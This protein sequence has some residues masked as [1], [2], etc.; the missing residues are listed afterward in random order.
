MRWVMGHSKQEQILKLI[1]EY[2]SDKSLGLNANDIIR[3]KQKYINDQRSYSEILHELTI[4]K[5]NALKQGLSVGTIK[6]MLNHKRFEEPLTTMQID[7]IALG[8]VKSGIDYRTFESKLRSVTT[9]QE[10]IE[11]IDSL[12]DEEII[13]DEVEVA[14]RKLLM[15]ANNYHLQELKD[16]ELI[17]TPVI[18]EHISPAENSMTE[19][20]KVLI[21]D[22][23]GKPLHYAYLK[24]SNL[25]ILLDN[26]III[27]SLGE[28]LQVPVAKSAR[29]T[30]EHVGIK[31]DGLVS[32]D[33]A[34]EQEQVMLLADLYDMVKEQLSS[35]DLAMLTFKEHHHNGEQPH[36]VIA[37]A[38]RMIELTPK[39][40]DFD[41]K[42]CRR[43]LL[44][45]L[46]FDLVTNQ[47]DR[48]WFN[49]ALVYNPITRQHRIGDLFDNGILE[50]QNY[51]KI[52][53]IG[54]D[55]QFDKLEILKQ[56]YE[57]YY[58]DIQ[59]LSTRIVNN[60]AL[61]FQAMT[62]IIDSNTDLLNANYLKSV[63]SDN[64]NALVLLDQHYREKQLSDGVMQHLL[65]G[66][67]KSVDYLQKRKSLERERISV[68]ICHDILARGS[69][70][71]SLVRL[72]H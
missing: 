11:Y 34:L 9:G 39:M 30:A 59:Y 55:H 40:R 25:P 28:I 22:Y 71:K 43:Q 17:D 42:Q 67:L 7:H 16:G 41:K 20:K 6:I 56:L 45:A 1:D 49:L 46:L 33:I 4:L 3:L 70:G 23:D 52:P 2:T 10:I 44:E 51:M 72:K 21:R 69:K 15:H 57:Y 48:N 66:E 64:L 37:A 31:V 38:I 68:Q 50:S 12:N 58:D 47:S 35:K 63:I 18:L 5:A 19:V 14:P 62:N 32:Y 60:K 13:S 53:L 26:E 24:T 61:Y 29:I 65:T 27:S 8:F 36:Q 54:H